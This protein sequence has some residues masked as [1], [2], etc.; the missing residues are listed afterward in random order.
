MNPPQ[1]PFLRIRSSVL[2]KKNVNMPH[3]FNFTHHNWADLP[4]Q[5]LKAARILG[6]TQDIWDEEK[7]LP[8]YNKT[9]ATASIQEKQAA[10]YLGM[11][12]L[13]EKCDLDWKDIDSMTKDY[14]TTLGWDETKWDEDWDIVDLEIEHK[15]WKDLTHKERQAAE[16]FGYIQCTWD[17]VEGDFAAVRM[18][19]I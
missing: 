19:L 10:M 8:Y 18:T 11:D 3:H 17:E 5:A 13:W 6:Y 4:P 14:A 15:F 16:Y 7:N 9:M 12:P 1:R 2:Q